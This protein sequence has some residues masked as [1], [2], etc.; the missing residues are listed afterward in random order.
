VHRDRKGSNPN[1][2][3]SINQ[4][5][6]GLFSTSVINLSLSKILKPRSMMRAL[7]WNGRRGLVAVRLYCRSCVQVA[8]FLCVTLPH[9]TAV[10][11]PHR[12]ENEECRVWKTLRPNNRPW[13]RFHLKQKFHSIGRCGYFA[14]AAK[15]L[16]CALAVRT[17]KCRVT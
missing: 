14:A 2:N 5:Y 10:W 13:A 4:L 7:A 17:D 8:M 12:T 16:P 15:I 9:S 1:A 11:Q 6:A 3:K